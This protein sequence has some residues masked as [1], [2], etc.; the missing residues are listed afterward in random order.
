MALQ[1]EHDFW[2]TLSVVM[3]AIVGVASLALIV[4]RNANTVGV[5]QATGSAFS[6][7][8]GVALSPVTGTGYGQSSA[9]PIA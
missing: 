2:G 5:I 1:A 7:S 3:L 8:L 9:F 6:N 4:S